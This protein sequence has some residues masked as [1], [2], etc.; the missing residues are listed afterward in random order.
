MLRN[1]PLTRGNGSKPHIAEFCY[2]TSGDTVYVC[3]HY[4]NGV[5][6]ADYRRLI[7][8]DPQSKHWRWQVMRR[9]PQVYVKGRIRHSDHKRIVLRGWHRVVMNTENESHALRN[10]AFLD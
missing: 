4:P 5:T 8:S 9:N 10:V 2:R 7:Q 1:E 6:E 3:R